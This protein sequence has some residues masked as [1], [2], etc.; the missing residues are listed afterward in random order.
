MHTNF[1]RMRFNTKQVSLY[2]LLRMIEVGRFDYQSYFRLPSK[3]SIIYKSQLIESIM[4]GLPNGEVWAEEDRYGQINILSG[5]DIIS[6]LIEFKEGSFKLKGLRYLHELEGVF[7]DE[8]KYSFKDDL[9]ESILNLNVLHYDL[10]PLIKCLFLKNINKSKLGRISNQVARNLCFRRGD[11]ELRNFSVN[12]FER[13]FMRDFGL[14]E[15]VR[16][17]KFDNFVLSFQEDILFFTLLKW[18]RSKE[19][20]YDFKYDESNH[21]LDYKQSNFHNSDPS[22]L[23]I[24]DQVDVAL[25]K[26][27]FEIDMSSDLWMN[28]LHEVFYVVE[29]ILMRDS[30]LTKQVGVINRNSINYNHD[31]DFF[32]VILRKFD[33]SPLSSFR[34]IK[35]ESTL[36][37]LGKYLRL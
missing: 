1:S 8:L 34:L 33:I 9:F 25:D 6:T 16:N 35:N 12:M 7:F 32:K 21:F 28:E 3:W 26:I 18:L 23:M 20:L 4:M 37:Q 5:I 19:F 29:E 11:E 17:K 36:L 30:S 14:K 2:E 24:H 22:V 13:F 15:I 10:H 27:M 31:T